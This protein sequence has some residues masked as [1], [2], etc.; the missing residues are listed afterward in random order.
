MNP[1]PGAKRVNYPDCPLQKGEG[2]RQERRE[3]M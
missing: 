1:Q 2:R 3:V